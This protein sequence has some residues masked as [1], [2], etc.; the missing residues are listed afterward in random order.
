MANS[1]LATIFVSTFCIQFCIGANVKKEE[2]RTHL[3]ELKVIQGS[4][5]EYRNM[6]GGKY[7]L[8]AY[9]GSKAD[10]LDL[11]SV[12]NKRINLTDVQK[13][14]VKY[15]AKN[16][17]YIELIT[18]NDIN[19][20]VMNHSFQNKN[21]LIK[22]YSLFSEKMFLINNRSIEYQNEEFKE[23]PLLFGKGF[24]PLSRRI[25]TSEPLYVYVFLLP[26]KKLDVIE[27]WLKTGNKI[28]FHS[29]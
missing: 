7:Y 5:L 19:N 14:V 20:E 24:I 1:I 18:S 29:E 21:Q 9:H 13:D 23:P 11:L 2:N 28:E 3:I 10:I 27:M 16:L 17:L 25:Y 15:D 12:R 8:S 4:E 6:Y 26:V 22:N